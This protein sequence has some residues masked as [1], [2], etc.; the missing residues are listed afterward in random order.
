LE[1]CLEIYL[2]I[3]LEIYLEIIKIEIGNGNGYGAYHKTKNPNT[4]YVYCLIA[5]KN[6]VTLFIISNYLL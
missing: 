4:Y 3:C 1:I 2:E 6:K 5:N